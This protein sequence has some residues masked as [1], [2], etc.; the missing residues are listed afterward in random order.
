MNLLE[1]YKRSDLTGVDVLLVSACLQL[2]SLEA[3]DLIQAE[4]GIPV[5]SAA[6]C[7]TYE[8]K[9]NLG[10]DVQSAIGG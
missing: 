1:I 5:T 2:L 3:V 9:K 4:I 7:T 8:I 10:V 6:A